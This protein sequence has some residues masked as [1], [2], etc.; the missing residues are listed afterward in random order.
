M[1]DVTPV[2]GTEPVDPLTIPRVR[3]ARK[4]QPNPPAALRVDFRGGGC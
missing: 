1:V 3:G 4:T 2:N